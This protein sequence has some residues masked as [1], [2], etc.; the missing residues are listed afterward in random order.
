MKRV[1]PKKLFRETDMYTICM[2][3]GLKDYRLERGLHDLEDNFVRIRDTKLTQELEVT[4][5]EHVLLLAF[6]A[7][8]HNRTKA[9]RDHQKEQWGRIFESVEEMRKWAET[10]TPEQKRKAASYPLS[11]GEKQESLGYEDVKKL[12]SEPMQHLLF[13]TIGA[14]VPLLYKLDCAVF[15]TDT[16]PGFITSDRPCVWFDSKAYLR[17]PLYRAPA[18]MYPTIEITMP[19]SPTQ[20]INLNRAGIGGYIKLAPL[21]VEE[22]NRRLRF[23]CDEYFVVNK[24]G[25]NRFW[26]DPGIEPEDSWERTHPLKGGKL[27]SE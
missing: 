16:S 24:K 17:A 6:V 9:Q 7:A 19:I 3:T 25:I 11:P 14:E 22:F 26:F 2:P 5:E 18:L 8:M 20:M 27:S 10:A 23:C 4:I 13:Q 21:Q 12:A 1:A 15:T